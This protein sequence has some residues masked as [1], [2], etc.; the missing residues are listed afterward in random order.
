M[1]RLFILGIDGASFDMLEPWIAAGDLPGFGELMADGCQAILQSSIPPLSPVAWSSIASG[2]NPGKHG[3]YDF[4]LKKHG[5]DNKRPLFSFARGSDRKTKA[6]WEILSEHGKSSI[7]VNMPCSFPPDP[8]NGLMI[9]GW[10]SA[11]DRAKGFYPGELYNEIIEKFGAY[12]MGPFDLLS[13]S[14]MVHTNPDS[15]RKLHEAMLVITQLRRKALLHLAREHSWDTFFGVFTESD[16]VQ[17]RFWRTLG[18]KDYTQS[19]IFQVYQE[20]DLFI[21]NLMKDFGKDIDIMV[22]SDHG[23]TSLLTGL[24]LNLYLEQHGFLKRRISPA[25]FLLF[26][27]LKRMKTMRRRLKSL[28][29][30]SW[31]PDRLGAAKPRHMVID[32]PNTRLFF[33]GTYPYFYASQPG[34]GEDALTE[35]REVLTSLQ[36][37]GETVFKDVLPANEAFW[38][39]YVDEL[40]EFIGILNDHF[41]AA[42]ADAFMNQGSRNREVFCD[43]VWEGNHT[44]NGIFVFRGEDVQE[45]QLD[46]LKVFDIAPTVLGYY[47]VAVPREMDG[48][49]IEAILGSREIKYSDYN[50]YKGESLVSSTLGQDDASA[51]E[52][53]LK[54]LGY[55]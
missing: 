28:L 7:V 51:I 4:L 54:S 11:R 30:K 17:H 55:L 49:P 15:N 25:G 27:L 37:Q 40:P 16:V 39:P 24:D 22:V 18:S 45:R 12:Y 8:I 14:E 35:L 32:F 34:R 5:G 21:Q 9:S 1:R 19:P 52:D 53:R 47:D 38:G 29:S 13:K 50:I 6:F 46:R 10:D 41:E 26:F 42:G 3:V 20:I 23:F 48:K 36:Y 43:H 31:V 44:E 2:V 33:E